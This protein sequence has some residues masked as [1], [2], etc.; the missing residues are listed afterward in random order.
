[1]MATQFLETDNSSIGL[2]DFRDKSVAWSW[3]V[4]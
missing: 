3:S 1:M 4:V 2:L